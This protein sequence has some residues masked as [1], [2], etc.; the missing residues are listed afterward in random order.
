MNIPIREYWQVISQFTNPVHIFLSGL[1]S[2]IVAL[3]VLLILL[4]LFRKTVRVKRQN[5]SLK[6]LSVAYFIILPLLAGFFGFKW[7][8]IRGLRNDLLAHA[9]VY[10]KSLNNAYASDVKDGVNRIIYGGAPT[11]ATMAMN[12][13]TNEVIDKLSDYAW[14]EYL[15]KMEYTSAQK[16]LSGRIAGLILR[17]TNGKAISVAVKRGL[18]KVLEDKI[19]INEE[20][21]ASLMA[22]K[23]NELL[24]KGLFTTILEIEIKKIFGGMMRG[25]VITFCIIL[26]L[27]VIEIIIAW[28]TARKNRTI[29]KQVQTGQPV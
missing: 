6:Y 4:L 17:A 9:P 22:T 23:W 11:Q 5:N 21:S 16:D 8:I 13:S 18:R 2:G 26:L 25:V 20:V 7:G 24:E 14:T 27:P 29:V 10:M 19:G 12:I 15:Q 3:F 1:V 28:R